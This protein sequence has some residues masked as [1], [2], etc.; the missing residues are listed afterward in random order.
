M[1]GSSEIKFT[2]PESRYGLTAVPESNP[3]RIFVSHAFTES[4]DYLRVFEYLEGRPNFYYRNTANPDGMP[5]TGGA[6]AVHEELRRQISLA[7][8]VLMPVALFKENNALAAFELDAA[9][10]LGIPVVGINAFG[11][12]MVV[13]KDVEPYT[14]VGGVAAQPLR[15]RFDRR[16]G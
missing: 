12:T 5:D 4:D 8:V 3:I 2:Y 13:S 7:E 16:R 6:D 1:A 10:G 9:N 14:I 15:R 11:A